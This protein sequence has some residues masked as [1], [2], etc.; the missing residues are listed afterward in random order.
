MTPCGWSPNGTTG[1]GFSSARVDRLEALVTEAMIDAACQRDTNPITPAR[2]AK[3]RRNI[4]LGLNCGSYPAERIYNH[5]WTPAF[6][7]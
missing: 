3:A 5:E 7:C 2:R 1:A 6:R 4:A